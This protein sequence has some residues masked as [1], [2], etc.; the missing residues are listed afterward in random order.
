M[1]RLILFLFI[2]VFSTEAFS[3]MEKGYVYLKNGTILKGKFQYSADLKKLKI[4]S[5]GNVWVFNASEID[6]VT[7]SKV[8]N[9]H[10]L[11]NMKNDSRI[12][13]RMELGIMAG[14]T[15]NSQSAPLT[16][17]AQLNYEIKPKLAVGLGAG[18]E[19]YKETYLPVFLNAEYKLRNLNSTPY[20]FVNGGYLLSI[21]DSRTMYYDYPVSS[22]MIW[23][24]YNYNKKLDPTGGLFINPGVGYL[25]YF[26]QGLGMSFSFGYRYH[27]LHYKGD[28]DYGLDMDYNRLSVK[29]GLLFK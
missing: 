23:P 4:E 11:L 22:S 26:N 12:F 9:K 25:H 29:L 1:Y 7:T 24:G 18:I 13:S 14:N 27:R 2:L 20:F 17:G 28:K 21:E 16:F 10:E 5:A 15:D 19:F 6:S 8:K 3:Q